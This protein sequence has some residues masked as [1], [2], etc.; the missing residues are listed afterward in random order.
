METIRAAFA[1]ARKDLVSWFRTPIH[2]LLSFAPILVIMLL[3]GIFYAG[4]ETMPV[5]VVME[6]PD[7]PVSRQFVDTVKDMRTAHFPWFNVVTE[8]AK[9][10][11]ELFEA[12]RV[13]GVIEVPDLS[14]GLQ[15]GQDAVVRLR[16]ANL[17]DDITKN[18]RQRVQEACLA[19][20]EKVQVQ[21][22]VR[23]Y[24]AAQ[25]DFD[26][27]LPADLPA[28]AFFGAGLVALAIVMGSINNAATLVA[29]EFEEKTYKELVLAP[30]TLSIVLGKWGSALVQTFISVALV[31][32]LATVFCQFIPQ[33][34]LL[35]LL[36][37]VLV[38]VVAFAGLGTLLGIYFKQVV[39]AA[40]AGMVFAIIGWWFGGM[41]WAD[42]WPGALQGLI[43]ALPTTY[44]I[45]AFTR[46]SL[47][48]LY[49][50]YWLD[51][52]VLVLFGAIMGVLAYVL[53]KRKIV[54]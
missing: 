19:F 50:T 21:S 41:I 49:T 1:L 17:N 18:F 20:N 48:G 14:A 10:A 22:S 24:P 13:L 23:V 9:E 45:R 44:L 2:V 35:P 12:S 3:L 31:W 42:I 8:D 39:P 15:A 11:E 53:L 52:G 7:D 30:S 6:A 54:V 32:G 43:A 28:L 51:V 16:I 27:F 36:L 4:A 29:R 40:I 46:A 34:G 37:L 25:A 5:A 38:G 26:T 47:L 33:G